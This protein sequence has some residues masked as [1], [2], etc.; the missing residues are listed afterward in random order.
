[1]PENNAA[2]T[3]VAAP[4]A[5]PA[6]SRAS[7][8]RLW[9]KLR[10]WAKK[11]AFITSLVAPI[12]LAFLYFILMASP[13]YISQASFAI[14]T[15]DNA[16]PSGTDLAAMFLKAPGSTGNDAYIVNDYIQSLDEN[17]R[18]EQRDNGGRK[19]GH[20]FNDNAVLNRFAEAGM[21]QKVAGETHQPQSV[22][23]K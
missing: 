15:A 18:P 13:M 2:L 14:R 16:A 4:A 6:S 11:R 1:M 5:S 22:G 8:R 20:T 10:R 9:K 21:A 7:V 12:V 23:D 19:K 3:T 17:S